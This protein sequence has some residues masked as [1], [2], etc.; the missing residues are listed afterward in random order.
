MVSINIET[1]DSL[2]AFP[3]RNGLRPFRI[4]FRPRRMHRHLITWTRF[5]RS[6]DDA[7][8]NIRRVLAETYIDPEL[9][10]IE[11]INR[12]FRDAANG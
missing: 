3:L 9:V 2:N 7:Q 4:T 10:S 8:S 6:F 1:A 11:M 5:Y 12:S